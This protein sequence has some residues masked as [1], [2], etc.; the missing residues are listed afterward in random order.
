GWARHLTRGIVALLALAYLVHPGPWVT[1]QTPLAWYASI[2][3]AIVRSGA[4]AWAAAEAFREAAMARRRV[5]LGLLSSVTARRFLLWGVAMLGVSS[6]SAVPLLTR[7]LLQ[8]D[9]G[10]DLFWAGLQS[11]LGLIAALA[12]GTAFLSPG[13][14]NELRTVESS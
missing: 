6:M 8:P 13:R 3:T 1:A 12:M 11:F 4:F 9:P 14:A 5:R 2:A 7:W 10:P